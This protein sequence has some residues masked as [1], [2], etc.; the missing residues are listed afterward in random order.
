MVGLEQERL[1]KITLQSPRGEKLQQRSVCLE[2]AD[3]SVWQTRSLH[4][5]DNVRNKAKELGIE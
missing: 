4:E 1:R 3:Y 5:R 2:N